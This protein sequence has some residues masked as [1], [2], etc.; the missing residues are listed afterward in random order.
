MSALLDR[1][2]PLFVIGRGGMG[3]VEAAVERGVAGTRVVALKRLLP[4]VKDR[5]HT[6]MFLREARLA[7]LLD[8]K[9]VVHALAYGQHDEELLFAME[10]VEGETLSTLLGAL[11]RP[12]P[13]EVSAWI[14]AELCE[15]LHAAHELRDV[16]GAPLGVVHRDVSPH[17]VMLSYAGDVKLLDFGVAKLEG[18]A[19]LT[20]TGEVKGKTAY[21][22]PEQAHGDP[23]D[24]RSDLY[25][26]G[27]ILFELVAGRRMWSG[28]T[29]LD[30]LRQL[31]LAEPPL[32]TDAAPD[33]PAELA[34]LHKR[35]VEKDPER[36]PASALEVTT[37]LRRF[38]SRSKASPKDT[39]VGI[40][41]ELFGREAAAKR[42]RLDEALERDARG[43]DESPKSEPLAVSTPTATPRPSRVSPWIYGLAFAGMAGLA[44]VALTAKNDRSQTAASSSSA[45]PVTSALAAS[46]SSGASAGPVASGAPSAAV[47]TQSPALTEVARPARTH[48]G[49]TQKP[50]APA[51]PQPSATARPRPVIDVDPN[52]I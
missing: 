40:M 11:R 47:N 42:Q 6:D 25:G 48:P 28:E 26:V 17:N 21:M 13:P 30:F 35:L 51:P 36:R 34:A 32:L 7:A 24:R 23:L 44:A 4:H 31:A 3:K 2:R 27:A 12:L 39:L 8:H 1:Y 9:N 19:Q 15:G 52:P 49:A 29:D 18:V 20:K 37:E 22:S 14:L 46:A 41:T 33:T 10:Y 16:G 45:P 38:A 50:H 43:E 5:R